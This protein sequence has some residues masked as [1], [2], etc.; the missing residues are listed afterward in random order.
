MDEEARAISRW[1]D[2]QGLGIYKDAFV[3]N[4]ITTELLPELG[5]QDLRDLGLSLGHRRKFTA[6][7][8]DGRGT[9]KTPR[10]ESERRQLT[11]MFCDLVGSTALSGRL[12][13]EDLKE[14]M[15]SYQ[16]ACA[17]A[18]A[19]YEGVVAKLLGDGVLAYFG[20]PQAH[21]D[22]AERAIRAGLDVIEK[23]KELA[24]DP[25]D[26]LQVRIGIATGPVIVGDMIG[27]RISDKDTVV[28]ETPNLAARLQGLAGPN[29][30][31][32]S[33]STNRLVD[34][35][36]G[37]DDLGQNE[38]K[39]FA[40]P[41][42]AWRVLSETPAESRFEASHAANLSGFIGREHEVSL[43]L[44]RWQQASQG[45]GQVVLLS[46]EAGIGKSRIVQNLRER[47]GNDDC[48][49][50]SYQC[51]P[52]HAN[53]ALYP[54]I[55]QVESACQLLPDD[56]AE[57]RLQKLKSLLAASSDDVDGVLPYFCSL[58]SLAATEV[59]RQD[60][61]PQELKER[62][63]T[64]LANQ[65]VNVAKK[66]PVL[67]IV[68]D[69][70][71]VDPTT[72][73]LIGR[74][75]SRVSH[76]RVMVVVTYRPGFVPPWE[77]YPN[78]TSLMIPRLNRRQCEAITLQIVDNSL[79]PEILNEITAR[80]DG[81]P[82][83]V[84][85]LTKAVLE[86]GL[87]RASVDGYVLDGPLS[88]LAIPTTIQDS[89]T[90]RLDRL[91][92][93]KEVAQLAAAIGR[94]FSYEL[95]AASAS[96][97]EQELRVAL[98]QLA[99]AELIFA[100]G[101]PPQATYTFRHALV[102]DA[103][104][105]TL[106]RG[107]RQQI[108]GKIARALTESAAGFTET[109]PELL[110]HH[111]TEAGLLADAIVLWQRAGEH[112]LQKSTNLEAIAHFRK[113]IQLQNSLETSPEAVQ[114]ELNMQIAMAQ[115]LIATKG[116]AADETAEAFE[117]ARTI[118]DAVGTGAEKF[119]VLYGLCIRHLVA[120]K[121]DAAL[122]LAR[123]LMMSV[124]GSETWVTS[125]SHRVLGSVLLLRGELAEAKPH[126]EEAIAYYDAGKHGDLKFRL[127]QDI[128]VA[129]MCYQSWAMW[130]LGVPG[131]AIDALAHARRSEH[132]HTLA[133]ALYYH[134]IVLEMFKGNTTAVKQNALEMA[135]I[136]QQHG[137][138]LWPIGGQIAEAWLDGRRDG[139]PEAIERLRTGMV[140][141][142]KT[143]SELFRPFYL[144]LYSEVLAAAG[145]LDEALRTLDE[146]LSLAEST[147]ERWFEPELRRLRAELLLKMS[148][149][150]SEEAKRW[151][152]SS[153]SVAR[154][155]GSRAWEMRTEVSL[156]RL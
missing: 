114:R 33:Q 65:L 121:L 125:V 31:V 5:D 115:A 94:E 62:T 150:N 156:A 13:P 44:D 8:K 154:A 50:L 77:M 18:I 102:R 130:L 40:R 56:N 9:S 141:Y 38:L 72:L 89:L 32:I 17:G 14:V 7:I 28:G 138:G 93:I 71:W 87:L 54:V 86:T 82:L 100:R 58:L 80:A 108:H 78:V 84:E 135:E 49:R 52:Y 96:I 129:A 90:A 107:K 4:H 3:K 23:V 122:A 70:H 144:S 55:R 42:Q 147:A 48:I 139:S 26:Q 67:L 91:A 22:D 143:G 10:P 113:G 19:R 92:P 12:D 118:L 1:L 37:M 137:L 145:Q 66:K 60:L 6:A 131:Q 64:S 25:G 68:E 151:L 83:F 106:L 120:G 85:E 43:L 112:A 127:N 109:Q 134:G 146:G 148:S 110:A 103:A 45:D 27:E 116:Y 2:D 123:Q 152:E 47:I 99:N 11:I 34:G 20:F 16:D 142:R 111:L 59:P 95:L 61:S 57:T 128:G 132:A 29:E 69:A 140:S 149:A 53:S 126:L 35:L 153:L 97:G 63:L 81:I 15:T 30:I 74:T 39:G 51:S 105:S 41:V 79:P 104:Y 98:I 117:R 155:Q 21:E 76:L 88:P 73:E 24:R 101:T 133:Y 119:T 75:I 46:G 124:D 36:F 136:S